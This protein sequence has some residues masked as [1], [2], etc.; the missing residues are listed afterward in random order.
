MSEMQELHKKAYNGIE[1]K[2]VKYIVE[3]E[4]HGQDFLEWHLNKDGV[5]VDCKPFQAWIWVGNVVDLA[6]VKQGFRLTME[7]GDVLNYPTKKV[8][9]I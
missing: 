9:T 2:K 7:S 6:T 3:I 1:D 4:D 8:K 5:V